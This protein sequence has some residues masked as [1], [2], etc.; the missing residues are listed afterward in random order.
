MKENEKQVIS[1]MLGTAGRITVMNGY[2]EP[3]PVDHVVIGYSQSAKDKYIGIDNLHYYSLN[4][5]SSTKG[6]SF[7]NYLVIVDSEIAREFMFD[8]LGIK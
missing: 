8:S 3:L 4:S 2:T 7:K 1:A 6:R 5:L